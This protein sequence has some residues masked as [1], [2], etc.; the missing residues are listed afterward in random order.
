MTF[1]NSRADGTLDDGAVL[2]GPS[3][4]RAVTDLVARVA[5]FFS[6]PAPKA[7]GCLQSVADSIAQL[8]AAEQQLVAEAQQHIDAL[9]AVAADQAALFQDQLNAAIEASPPQLREIAAIPER[10]RHRAAVRGLD[11]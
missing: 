2:A 7:M 6:H 11:L 9:N 4:D 1:F 5:D 8:S 10:V 3:R